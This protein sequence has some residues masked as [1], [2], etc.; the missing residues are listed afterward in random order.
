MVMFPSV[1]VMA[2]KGL[3]MFLRMLTSRPALINTLPL[4]QSALKDTEPEVRKRAANHL[5]IGGFV[6][7]SMI[8]DP[9]GKTVP[10]SNDPGLPSFI[11]DRKTAFDLAMVMEKIRPVMLQLIRDTD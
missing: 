6:L 3:M 9:M 8:A 1:V 11:M 2:V 7:T 4:V 10:G 5:R